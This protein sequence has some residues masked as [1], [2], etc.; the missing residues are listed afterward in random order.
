MKTPNRFSRRAFIE[1][2]LV[3]GLGLSLNLWSCTKSTDKPNPTPEPPAPDDNDND[4][5]LRITDI[6]LPFSMYVSTGMSLVLIG[7]NFALKDV[8]LFQPTTGSNQGRVTVEIKEVTESNCSI[9]LPSGLESNRYQVYVQRG[10]KSFLLG[11]TTLNV[12]FDATLPDRTGM[13]IKGVVYA[14]GSGLANVVVSDGFEVTKTDDQGIY[15]LKSAKKNKYIFVSI[16][17]QYE[18]QTTQSLPLFFKRLERA[19]HIVEIMDFELTKVDNDDHV[20]MVLGDMHLANRNQDVSQFQ[21]GFLK[22]LNQS[23]EKYKGLGKKV[24][25]LTLGDM[26]WETY[27]ASTG[28]GLPEYLREMNKINAPVFN[29]MGN[30]DNDPAVSGDWNSSERFRTV[31]GPNY[32]SFNIGKVHYVVL[33]N[34]EYLNTPIGNRN[35]NGTISTDQMEW[36]RKDLGMI[37]D[38]STP[39]VIAMH[40]NLFSNPSLSGG[41]ETRN[42]RL[43]NSQELIDVLSAFST[44]HIYSGH[45]HM[46]YNARYSPALMEHNIGVV[47]ATWW[48]TGALANTH[49]C[50]DGT[51]GGY[52]IWQANNREVQWV[53][54]SIGEPEDYQFRSYDLNKVL[55]T[56]EEYAPA[57]NGSEWNTYAVEYANA[58]LNNE[59]LINVWNYDPEW[60]VEVTE[61]GV[62]LPVSRV[63]TRDPLH[64]ISYSAKR[65]NQNAVPTADF[66]T[67]LSAHMFKAKAS[68]PTSTIEI[69][70]TDCFGKVYK[71][72]MI[73]PK[74]LSYT[75]K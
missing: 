56:K 31:I 36:L 14:N 23:I 16:P 7:K 63:R 70:V 46:N 48:W 55:L 10:D 61:Q 19:E 52:A 12:V 29:T 15:Y 24:Y 62:P 53:Y 43:T 49:I 73:R 20:V 60:K 2:T 5:E 66:V 74:N 44:V 38:K 42:N 30:H 75:M 6:V 1:T 26:T 35:Y 8:I 47:C 59:I 21:N 68:S 51:P 34:I 72:T 45:T 22:D 65:L 57:Y 67:G 3:T 37:E 17:A 39:I 32:Y 9:I 28:F 64:I 13:T 71:E 25:A 27:W 50:K 41:N 58:N 11:S 4:N 40:I 33:D 54:K 18:V 69:K